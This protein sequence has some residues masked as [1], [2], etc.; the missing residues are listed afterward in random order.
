MDLACLITIALT[1]RLVRLVDLKLSRFADAELP[2]PVPAPV[3]RRILFQRKRANRRIMNEDMFV[4]MLREFGEVRRC[5]FAGC[6]ALPRGLA[7]CVT[8]S[9]HP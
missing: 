4:S 1:S 9:C 5:Q 2:P 8:G 3:P 7:S 6:A